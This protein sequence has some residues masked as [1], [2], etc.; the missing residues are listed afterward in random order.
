MSK[1]EKTVRHAAEVLEA[2]AETL[3]HGGAI[4]PGSC[5]LGVH[6]TYQA[7]AYRA[8]RDLRKLLDD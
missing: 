5:P 6:T 3:S 8:A 7:L 1:R 4:H 2:V